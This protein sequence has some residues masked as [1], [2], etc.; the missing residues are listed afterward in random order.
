MCKKFISLL[1][2]FFSFNTMSYANEANHLKEDQK[3]VVLYVQEMTCQLCVYLVNKELRAIEGVVSTKAGFKDRLVKVIAQ[4]SVSEE[5]LIKAI[6]KLDY[7]AV[8]KN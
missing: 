4:K 7:S 8:V 1:I 2:L 3:Q 6:N 5:T